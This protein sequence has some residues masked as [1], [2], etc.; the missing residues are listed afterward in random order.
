MPAVPWRERD[1]SGWRQKW[2][3][4]A[5]AAAMQKGRS[6]AAAAFLLLIVVPGWSQPL[7]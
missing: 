4:P 7:A 5:A 6:V 2:Q 1:E 3:P